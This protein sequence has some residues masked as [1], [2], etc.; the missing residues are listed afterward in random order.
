MSIINKEAEN[1]RG[2][3][4]GIAYKLVQ[5]LNES[6]QN[7]NITTPRDLKDLTEALEIVIS[8]WVECSHISSERFDLSESPTAKL[9]TII[10][11]LEKG[12][13]EAEIDKN[14][15]KIREGLETRDMPTLLELLSLLVNVLLERD[16]DE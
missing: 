3:A 4:W 2:K 7:I 14:K 13:H 15:A 9:R 8:V 16:L 11:E 6:I 5:K 12:V 1:L 10:A